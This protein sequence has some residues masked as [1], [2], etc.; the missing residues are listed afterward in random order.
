[1]RMEEYLH[2]TYINI[3]Y[4]FFKIKKYFC[5]SHLLILFINRNQANTIEI[6]PSIKKSLSLF[7]FLLLLSSFDFVPFPNSSYIRLSLYDQLS[8]ALIYMFLPYMLS[9]LHDINAYQ[10]SLILYTSSIVFLMFS[11]FLST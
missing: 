3:S 7:I 8:F 9:K 5:L 6:S 1:M 2:I 10:S 11:V 4:I